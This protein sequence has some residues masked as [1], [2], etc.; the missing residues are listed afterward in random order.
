MKKNML[1][2]IFAAVVIGFF[3]AGCV[4]HRYYHENHRHSEK[5]ESRH[6]HHEE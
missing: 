5:Y 4:E 2:T 6:H 1:K 3:L